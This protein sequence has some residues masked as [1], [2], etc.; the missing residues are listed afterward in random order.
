MGVCPGARGTGLRSPCTGTGCLCLWTQHKCSGRLVGQTRRAWGRQRS[1]QAYAAQQVRAPPCI[2]FIC[3]PTLNLRV[4]GP[5]GLCPQR[6]CLS[7]LMVLVRTIIHPLPLTLTPLPI[8]PPHPCCLPQMP[9]PCALGRIVSPLLQLHQLLSPACCSTLLEVF[10]AL[11]GAVVAR[12]MLPLLLSWVLQPLRVPAERVGQEGQEGQGGQ[13]ADAGR[14]ISQ[15]QQGQLGQYGQGQQGQG[16]QLSRQPEVPDQQSLAL[17]LL[18]GVQ[19]LLPVD[20][21]PR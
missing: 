9:L 11:G 20:L 8:S 13:G 2:S 3:V 6:A 1:V 12:H 17:A 16:Q 4:L 19:H 18:E 10:K 21:L 15:V 7:V 14:K 5:R